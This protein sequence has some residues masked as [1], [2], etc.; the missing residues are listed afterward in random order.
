MDRPPKKMTVVER[1]PFAEVCLTVLLMSCCDHI[2]VA[3]R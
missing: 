2:H 3:K 1:W